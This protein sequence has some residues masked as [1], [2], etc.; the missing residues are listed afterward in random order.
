MIY[1]VFY[2]NKLIPDRFVGAAFGP[3]I[4]IRPH[5]KDDI[6]LLEHEKVHVRQFWRTLGLFAIPY[7]FSSKARIK[8]EV[9][10]Y[11]EQLKYS[12]NSKMVFA[13][14]LAKNYKANI[15]VEQALAL[16]SE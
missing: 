7:Y 2:T 15:T 5:K 16:L 13:Q 4:F 9:E 1:K 14:L 12:P 3:F 6:G 10:A 11:K 8:Y